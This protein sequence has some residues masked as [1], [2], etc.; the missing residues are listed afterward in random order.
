[1]SF[2]RLL[3]AFLKIGSTQTHP[4]IPN[5]DLNQTDS[6][7]LEISLTPENIEILKVMP[8]DF[9]YLL[10][11]KSLKNRENCFLFH[12]K[13]FLH[14]QDIQVFMFPSSPLP[15]WVIA[16][17]IDNF[18]VYNLIM[19][20]SRNTKIFLDI[21]GNNSG[22]ILKVDQLIEYCSRIFLKN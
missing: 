17:G 8:A 11:K 19:R 7:I 13:S 1:M 18:S 12:L 3:S 20:L 5:F 21:F 2:V 9:V 10:S 6:R 15:I 22:L 4:G 14:F 16:T